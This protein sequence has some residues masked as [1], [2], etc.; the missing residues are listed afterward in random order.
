[1]ADILW[2]SLGRCPSSEFKILLSD[3]GN[4]TEVQILGIEIKKVICMFSLGW[5]C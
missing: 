1:M 3:G 5:I 2:C 4:E